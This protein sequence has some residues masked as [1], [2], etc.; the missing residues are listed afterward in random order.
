MGRESMTASLIEDS[1]FRLT[2]LA[3]IDLSTLAGSTEGTISSLGGTA[4][5][6]KPGPNAR[7]PTCLRLT[8]ATSGG[9][10]RQQLTTSFAKTPMRQQRLFVHGS[11]RRCR[12]LAG[13]VAFQYHIIQL[14]AIDARITDGM[15]RNPSTS[16]LEDIAEREAVGGIPFSRAILR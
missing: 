10:I 3:D 5:H 7:R 8:I 9:D 11:L 2:M 14:A 13:I 1:I 6:Q 15:S 12:A 4:L 16:S